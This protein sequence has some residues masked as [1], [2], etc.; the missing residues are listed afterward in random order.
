VHYAV[1]SELATAPRTFAELQQAVG[2]PEA[3]LDAAL[4]V[5]YF[6]GSITVNAERAAR[7]GTMATRDSVSASEL[8]NSLFP[9][10]GPTSGVPDATMPAPLE[11]RP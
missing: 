1:L 3:Q 7:R 5:L 9:D 11:W 8:R 10:G 6:A 2:L 4:T